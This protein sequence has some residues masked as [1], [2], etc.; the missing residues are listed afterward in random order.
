MQ[1]E[2]LK[3]LQAELDV[4]KWN[5]AQEQGADTCGSYDYCGKCDKAAEYP[6]ATAKV[7]SETKAKKAPAKKSGAPRKP[8]TKKAE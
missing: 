5:D 7:A 3:N 8:R 4:K 1:N 6:C 2:E